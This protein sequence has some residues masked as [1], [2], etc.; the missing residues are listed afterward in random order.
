MK[1]LRIPYGPE[2]GWPTLGLVAAMLLVLGWS[3]D[4]VGWVL[5]RTEWTDFLAWVGVL[6]V[7][8]GF[9]GAKVG[10]NRWL[11]H[12]IGAVAAALIVP[13]IVGGVLVDGAPLGVRYAAT[14]S[15]AVNAWSDL[16]INQLP[17]T[18]ETGHHLLILGLVCWATGQFAASA[19]FRHR[20]PLG[21]IVVTGAIL[22]GN[23]AATIRDQ[24]GYL[25]L[26]TL[27]ALFLLI[28]LHALDEQATW[29]RRRIGDPTAV[30]SIYL[31]GGT[32][33]ILIAVVG[34]FALTATARSSPLAGAWEDLKPWLLD[35]SSEIQ[36]FLPAGADSRG[37]G[38]IQFG[39]NAPIQ[40][41]W[42]TSDALALTIRRPPG[43]KRPYYWRA[44]AYDNF[45]LYGW[46]WT[47]SLRQPRPAGED[48]LDG[49]FDQLPAEGFEDVVFTVTPDAYRSVYAVSPLGPVSVDRNADLIT[50][51]EDGFFAALDVGGRQPYVVKAR[52][53]VLGDETPGGL[54][55]NVLRAA[56]TEYPEEILERYIDLPEGS[57]GPE[58]QKVLDTALAKVPQRNPYDIARA[59]VRELQSSANF[60]Y[61]ANVLDVDCGD[62]SAAECFAW[63]RQGYCDHYATLMAVLLRHEGIPARFVHGFLPGS[64]DERTGVEEVRNTSAHAWVEAYFP[65]Y[66]WVQFDP[67]GGDVSQAEPLPSGQPVSPGPSRS[68]GFSSP[69]NDAEG[70]DDPRRSPGT[71]GVAGTTNRPNP[72]IGPFI[73]ISILLL[74]TV[75]LGAFLAWR[76][77]PRGPTT[78]ENAYAGV[79]RL[80]ARFGFGP[81]PTQ[82]AYEYA[83]ALGDVLPNV[84]PELQTV[85]A[86]KVEVAYGARTLGEDRIRALRESYR[87]LRVSLLRLVFRRRRRR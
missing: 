78:P 21:A 83:A 12:A 62:R 85:A 74:V 34:S 87:R 63:S 7:L 9:V 20:R 45:N 19:V 24:L 64:I 54:T 80:A 53:P 23:M 33:F 17:A 58:A 61:D 31:R 42:S 2:E 60:H 29:L 56:G 48:I 39:P 40:G 57:V 11:A 27:A 49:T 76:R 16:V 72:P 81:R 71:G 41:F 84:R 46:D 52:V 77:G 4:D 18:R 86:A 5:G 75:L 3:I 70:P 44:V 79:A 65:G 47:A 67:T 35:V 13:I 8:I 82:T 22:V 66:G 36:R 10:W 38:A 55:E 1:R 37:I 25:M 6:G 28:R 15:A 68:L 50:L 32:V 59:L 51:G 26:F 69:G 73:V 43:D 30:R 14:A